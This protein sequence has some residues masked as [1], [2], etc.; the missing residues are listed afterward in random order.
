[1][2]KQLNQYHVVMEVEPPFLQAPMR[3]RISTSDAQ[4]TQVPLTRRSLRPRTRRRSRSITRVSFR[5]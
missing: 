1:M 4:G 5:R 2:Y 3:C